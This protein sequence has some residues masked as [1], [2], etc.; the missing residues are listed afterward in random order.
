MNTRILSLA[1]VA[2]A[3]A[4][5]GRAEVDVSIAAE[6]RLGKVA[7]PPPPE[8]VIVTEAAPPGP[9]PWAPAHGFRRNHSYYYYPGYDVYYRTDDRVWFYLEGGDWRHGPSLPTT[10]RVDFARG[11]PLAME[12]DRPY[13]FHDKVRVYYPSNYFVT[14]VRVKDAKGDH[15]KAEHHEP[16]DGSVDSKGKSQGKG[17]GKDKK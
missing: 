8:V 6:I 5:P 7:P 14:Q 17:K 10:I 12:T 4:I 9:P 16:V 3:L 13:Q 11:V 15:G 2:A 1:C